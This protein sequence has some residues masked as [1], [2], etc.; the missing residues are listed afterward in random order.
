MVNYF[1]KKLMVKKKLWITLSMFLIIFATRRV[2]R[3]MCLQVANKIKE[4]F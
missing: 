4:M 2:L 1:Q 3:F